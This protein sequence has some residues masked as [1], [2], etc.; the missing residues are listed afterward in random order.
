MEKKTRRTRIPRELRE[1]AAGFKD[2]EGVSAHSLRLW[3][4]QWGLK[5][6]DLASK[7]LRQ[8]RFYSASNIR[9]MLQQLVDSIYQHVGDV[10]RER[11]AFVAAGRPYSGAAILG[12]ALRDTR[13]V[14]GSQIRSVPELLR[15]AD[16]EVEVAVFVEDFSGTGATLESW[17][18]T[19]E[20]LIL[21]KVPRIIF[22]ILVLNFAARSRLEQ[23]TAQVVRVEELTIADNVLS[24]QNAAFEPAEKALLLQYCERTGSP[25]KYRRGFGDCGLL[26]AFKHFC[27]NNSLPV[28]WFKHPK[29]RNL[30]KRT[31][32]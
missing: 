27:P 15:A 22:G 12:R 25:E 24:E 30:F 3:V 26:V 23:F 17:W 1:L 2:H 8:T 7:V 20:P 16:G 29:W 28:L 14:H 11:I 4:R 31:A 10:R 5:G 9:N 6:G 18:Y 13:G 21:P 32:I 19:I